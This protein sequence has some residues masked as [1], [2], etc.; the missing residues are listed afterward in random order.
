MWSD[1]KSCMEVICIVFGNYYICMNVVFVWLID[2][3]YGWLGKCLMLNNYDVGFRN[4]VS[5]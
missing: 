3:D 1:W 4:C 5:V 2:V